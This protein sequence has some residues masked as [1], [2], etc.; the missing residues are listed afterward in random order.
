MGRLAGKVVLIT[1]AANGAEGSLPGIGGAFA[2][3]AVREGAAVVIMDINEDRGRLTASQIQRNGGKALFVRLDVTNE[4]EWETAINETTTTFGSLQILVSCAGSHS[5]TDV[6]HTPIE[7]FQKMLDVHAKG[8]FLGSRFAVPEMRKSGGGSI[9]NISS[10]A[11]MIGTPSNTAYHAAKGAIRSFTKAA[12][13]QFA[14]D[15]IRVNSV[16]PGYIDTPF[17]VGPFSVPGALESRLRKVPMAR[18]G[19]AH[20]IADAILYLASDESSYVTGSELVGDGGLL[21]Q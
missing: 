21:A 11:A 8:T 17:T 7:E 20:E 2:W 6:E 18:L 12:A 5:L 16:H 9:I 10:T 3:T 19:K 1:G 4:S 14:S 15:R 13:I